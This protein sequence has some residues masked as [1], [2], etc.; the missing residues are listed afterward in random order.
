MDKPSEKEAPPV[1]VNYV[2]ETYT[3]PVVVF[4]VAVTWLMGIVIAKGA[5]STGFAICMPPYAWYLVVER[6]MQQTG[7]LV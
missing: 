3:S 4:I 6:I 2:K 5:W 7:L 1:V